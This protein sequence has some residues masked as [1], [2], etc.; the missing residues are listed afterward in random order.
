MPTITV[1]VALELPPELTDL[2]AATNRTLADRMAAA[3]SGAAFR[4]SRD[5]SRGGVR[6]GGP[7]SGPVPHVSLFMLAVQAAEVDEVLAAVRSVAQRCAPVRADGEAYRH[8][9]QGAPEVYF[10]RTP[11]WHLLQREVI[12]AVEPLRHGR[13]R[14]TGPAGD[15]LAEVVER[16]E[17]DDPGD[18][19]LRQLRRYGYDEV[20]DSDGDRFHPHVTLAWPVDGWRVGW[21]GLPEPAAFSA[22]LSGLGV[23]EMGGYGTC[24]HRFGGHRLT[25]PADRPATP[26]RPTVP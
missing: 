4:F 5:G 22:T 12:A 13:L 24:L 7:D 3:G 9:P 1:D 16:L 21:D 14:P 10:A 2:A 6:A 17:C 11:A 19:R 23:F 20:S 25:G 26:Q 8:N 18:A 15:V